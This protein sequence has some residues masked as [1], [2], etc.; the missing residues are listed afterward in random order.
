MLHMLSLLLWRIVRMKKYRV[1]TTS[2]QQ[3]WLIN[4][5]RLLD[6]WAISS[7]TA[8]LS[9]WMKF[10]H[11]SL[12][13]HFTMPKGKLS[14]TKKQ[15]K[16]DRTPS[17]EQWSHC[18]FTDWPLAREIK[19]RKKKKIYSRTRVTL[20]ILSGQLHLVYAGKRICDKSGA[21]YVLYCNWSCKAEVVLY[22]RG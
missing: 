19:R 2:V 12:T 17:S 14:K 15:K 5:P 8:R 9:A 7:F 6:P 16:N 13:P 11:V 18:N 20:H 21:I 1:F 10:V 3:A 4:P 22:I